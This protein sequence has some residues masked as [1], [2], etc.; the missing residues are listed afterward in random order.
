MMKT[1]LIVRHAKTHQPDIGQADYD[2]KLNSRGETDAPAMAKRMKERDIKIDALVS[3]PA[4]RAKQTCKAFAKEFGISKDEIIYKEDIYNAHASAY[5]EAISEL[6]NKI[7][8]VAIFG[9]NPGITDFA[10][11]LCE[12]VHIENMQTGSVFAVKIK[13]KDWSEFGS[14]TKKFLFYDY[15]VKG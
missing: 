14:A 1:L 8:T 4:K 7:D 13:I 11:K 15:P 3:S 9:H 6:K 12:E 10:D 5:F 2:R